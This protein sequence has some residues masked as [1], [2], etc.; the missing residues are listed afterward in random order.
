M[1]RRPSGEKTWLGRW[2]RVLALPGALGVVALSLASGCAP[3]EPPAAAGL[4]PGSLAE[5]ERLA[6]V[7]AFDDV[8]PIGESRPPELVSSRSELARLHQDIAS[9]LWSVLEVLDARPWFEP[10]GQPGSGPSPRLSALR[11]TCAR[12]FAAGV[13]GWV[14]NPPS[15]GEPLRIEF[16]RFVIKEPLLVDRFEVTRRQWL[17]WLSSGR[18]PSRTR[19]V[20]RADAWDPQGLDQAVAFVDHGEATAFA[21]WRGMRLLS[22]EEWILCAM[23]PRENYFPWGDA[24]Q[25][26]VANTLELGLGRPIAVGT[27]S[28]GDTPTGIADLLGNVAE[29]TAGRLPRTDSLPGDAR[30]SVLGGSYRKRARRTYVERS[31]PLEEL[32]DPQAR[33]SAVGL[34]CAVEARAYVFAHGA[35]WQGESSSRE[36]LVAIGRRWGRGALAELD[37]WKASPDAPE[38]V[39]LLREGARR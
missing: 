12:V 30:V 19:S 14:R 1:S 11:R 3:P 15:Q 37:A 6:F 25:D 18:A 8:F 16:R 39:G 5:F 26:S 4:V 33:D 36:R 22:A 27:F 28:V 7:S 34:R 32:L 29:W 2:R 10:D 23:G 38:A 9:S 24:W 20:V 21:A 31:F 35:S 17:A 13:E